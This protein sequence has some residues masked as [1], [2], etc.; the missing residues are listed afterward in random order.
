[1]ELAVQLTRNLSHYQIHR[2][3][4]ITVIK[5]ASK[6]IQKLVLLNCWGHFAITKKML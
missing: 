6:S 3:Y 4:E 2:I 5:T 1:M